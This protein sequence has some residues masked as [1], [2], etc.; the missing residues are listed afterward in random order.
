[1]KNSVFLV[2]LLFL[3]KVKD[4]TWLLETL[5]ELFPNP[6]THPQILLKSVKEHELFNK[7]L[8]QREEVLFST[9]L[10]SPWELLLSSNDN[11]ILIH[12]LKF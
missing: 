4:V 10:H 8:F 2:C 1:M 5:H 7:L 9:S 12:M 11:T 6:N 3:T